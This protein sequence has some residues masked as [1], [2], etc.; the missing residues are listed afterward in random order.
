ML[1][2]TDLLMARREWLLLLTTVDVAKREEDVS[3]TFTIVASEEDLELLIDIARQLDEAI[4]S[5]P[6]PV[7]TSGDGLNFPI[8]PDTAV[9]GLQI[10]AAGVSTVNGVRQLLE[11][12]AK[13]RKEKRQTTKSAA[14]VVLISD[15]KTGERLYSGSDLSV[16]DAEEIAASM[17]KGAPTE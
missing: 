4:V 11:A 10:V 6:E 8:D 15:V 16:E 3:Y 12:W 7:D 5:E 17:P 1:C 13:R 14:S 2:T 9:T